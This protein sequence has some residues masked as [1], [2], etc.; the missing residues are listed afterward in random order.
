MSYW[1]PVKLQPRRLE[2]AASLS[3]T[4]ALVKVLN[5][6]RHFFSDHVC[7]RTIRNRLEDYIRSHVPLSVEESLFQTGLELIKKEVDCDWRES[8]MVT[9]HM[10]VLYMFVLYRSNIKYLDMPAL[11]NHSDRVTALDLLYNVGAQYGHQLTTVKMKM[12]QHSNISIEENYLTKRVLRGFMEVTT[13]VLWRAADDAMLQIIG[14]T[15]KNLTSLDLWKCSKVTDTGVQMLLGLEAQGRTKLCSS[16]EKITIRD[17]AISHVGAFNLLLHCPRLHT[18]EFS[19]GT[20]IKQFLDL[21][22]ESYSA[23]GRQFSLKSLFLPVNSVS[24]LYSVIKSFPCLEEVSL[25]TSL[26]HLPLLSGSDLSAVKS[27]KI[28]GLNYSSFFTDT[29]SLIGSQLVSL[30]IETVHFDINIDVIGQHCPNIQDLSVINARLSVSQPWEKFYPSNT[31]PGQ[32]GMFSALRKIYLFLVSYNT[33]T[34]LPRPPTSVSDPARVESSP[35]TTT[36]ALHSILRLGRA[37]ETITVTGPS[38]LTDACLASVLRVNPLTELRRLIISLPSSQETCL[39]IPLT[40][41]SVTALAQS[42]PHLACLGDLRHWAISPA[43][44]RDMMRP[45]QSQSNH[46]TSTSTTSSLQQSIWTRLRISADRPESA[47]KSSSVCQQSFLRPLAQS[48]S[49]L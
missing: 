38:N 9:P 4:E 8:E 48:T 44:R 28:G 13:L 2:V 12:F 20:F 16:L 24:I 27:L 35:L 7:L 32:T 33:V 11:S 41:L 14:H 49:V 42:C 34:D 23:T 19:H 25:W 29:V 15:C 6:H 26:S 46:T 47:V 3:W 31:E 22:E 1:R 43:Q 30:K 39:V 36:T 45:P 40:L 10:Y 18:L 17:T 5:K 37:L 21:I